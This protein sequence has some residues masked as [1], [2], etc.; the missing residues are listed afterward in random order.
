MPREIV[1]FLSGMRN[2]DMAVALSDYTPNLQFADALAQTG[3]PKLLTSL[4][5]LE[6]YAKVAPALAP[7]AIVASNTS[8]LS[9]NA[10]AQALPEALRAAG[11]RTALVGKWHVNRVPDHGPTNYGY[12]YFF[13]V[14]AGAA[15]YF[16]HG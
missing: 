1:L 5:Q 14:A 2:Y 6:L 7:H 13:G 10:L 9:I 8:G 16:R 3:T 15:D 11:Y 12:D 4:T